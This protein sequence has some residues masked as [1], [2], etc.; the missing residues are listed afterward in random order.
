MNVRQIKEPYV[1]IHIVNTET[2]EILTTISD[3][4]KKK[5]VTSLRQNNVKVT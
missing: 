2:G 1:G 4:K 5:K 3:T